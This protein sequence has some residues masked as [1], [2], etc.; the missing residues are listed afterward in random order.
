MK[1][2]PLEASSIQALSYIISSEGLKSQLHNITRLQLPHK[3]IQK[4][5]C[6][7]APHGLSDQ[8]RHS[9]LRKCWLPFVQVPLPFS[10]LSS[11]LRNPQL[12]G[13]V[14]KMSDLLGRTFKYHMLF[15]VGT[16]HFLPAGHLRKSCPYH[17]H[18]FEMRELISSFSFFSLYDSGALYWEMYR[19]EQFKSLCPSQLKIRCVKHLTSRSMP[20]VPPPSLQQPESFLQVKELC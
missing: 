2:G 10:E 13:T 12:T 20:L 14:I 15:L 18:F 7:L 4:N 8:R 19:N 11:L 6:L 17:Q 16:S 5:A 3:E 1:N 9:A